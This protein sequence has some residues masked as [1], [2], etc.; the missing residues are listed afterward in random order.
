MQDACAALYPAHRFLTWQHTRSPK[1]RLSLTA[2][3]ADLLLEI[4]SYFS[5]LSDV[6]RLSLVVGLS[7]LYLASLA[8]RR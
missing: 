7:L 1:P 3:P 8:A 5:T 2:L 6:L 4:T